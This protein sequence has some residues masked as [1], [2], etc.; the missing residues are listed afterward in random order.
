MDRNTGILYIAD[1]FGNRIRKLTPDGIISTHAGDGEHDFVNGPASSARFRWPRGVAVDSTGIV[2]V[3]DYNNHCIRK[4]A[5]NTVSTLAGVCGT[6]GFNN[7]AGASALFNN[8]A[9]LTLDNSGNLFVAGHSDGRIRKIV[10]S[11]L[12][13]STFAGGSTM[14]STNGQGTAARFNYPYDV[15][16]NNSG[17]LFVA[18]KDNNMIRV[19]SPSGYVSLFAGSSSGLLDG[20][21]GAA[22]F[23][24]PSALAFDG[25][26]NLY[27][28]DY[29]NQG[30][31]KISPSGLVTS[32]TNSKN[33]EGDQRGPA[34][35]A[36]F[37][38]P[39]GIE[40]DGNGTIY[41]A[42]DDSNKIEII[43]NMT[44][45]NGAADCFG[46]RCKCDIG[47]TGANCGTLIPTTS[48]KQD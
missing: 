15:A 37:R 31:R 26:G 21:G 23:H 29:N 2:Y 17:Y 19:I 7:G 12:T 5:A 24:T 11:S 39:I 8:P 36:S 32:I 6:S 33:L 35:K 14:G 45:I 30:I 48:K 44:C 40:V 13:V 47:W 4:V 43:C 34:L 10:L 42:D 25:N 16:F 18:D 27:V 9:G 41:V 1:F 46:N 20:Q 3:S 28:A 38:H 22:M